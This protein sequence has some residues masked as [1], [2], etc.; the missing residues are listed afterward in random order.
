MLNKEVGTIE[1]AIEYFNSHPALFEKEEN[2]KGHMERV[3]AVLT[4][5]NMEN[6]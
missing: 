2:D 1:D 3:M 6:L 4:Q 5:D